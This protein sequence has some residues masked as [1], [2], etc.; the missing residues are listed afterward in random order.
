MEA[1]YII[2]LIIVLSSLLLL[3]C[4]NSS[5]DKISNKLTDI[6]DT[7]INNQ[8]IKNKEISDKKS[9]RKLNEERWENLKIMIDLTNFN[10]R[11]NELGLGDDKKAIFIRAINNAKSIL[12]SFIKIK[13]NDDN[14]D[15]YYDK[16]EEFELD[17]W[18]PQYFPIED[19][20]TKTNFDYNYVIFFRF[21]ELSDPEDMA[22]SKNY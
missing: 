7:I 14:L 4:N 6:N 2:F 9:R 22:S 1:K 17:E 12:E 3:D 8:K 10:F 11:A 5:N 20:Y 13:N 19:G 18:D 15:I 16:L 21:D